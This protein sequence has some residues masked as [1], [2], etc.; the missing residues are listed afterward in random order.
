M[1][2]VLDTTGL[3][4]QKRNK[5]FYICSKGKNTI[6]SPLRI[7]SILI[8]KDVYLSTSALR[9]AIKHKIPVIFMNP[10]GGIEGRVW[11]SGFGTDSEIRKNQVFFSESVDATKWIIELFKLKSESQISLLDWLSNRKPTLSDSI[12]KQADKI[13]KQIKELDKFKD[14]KPKDCRNNI[15]GIEG[16][17]AKYY[18]SGISRCMPDN[19]SFDGRSRQPA[20]DMFNA[21]LNYCYAILYSIVESAAISAGL[22]TQ[23]GIM[24]SNIYNKPTLIYDLIEPFR[25]WVD[26]FIVEQLLT[27]KI[28]IEYF[29]EKNGGVFLNKQGKK[30]LIPEFYKLIETHKYFQGKRMKLKNHINVFAGKLS[31]TLKDYKYDISY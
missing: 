19:F 27:D 3:K 8:T 17:C 13:S 4:I 24:H 6:V 23:F 29:E 28:K 31:L 20:N 10:F 5:C 11:H 7:D 22:D 12:K 2:L 16:I 1:Q 15:L 14:T 9:L 18:W 30:Y 21:T 25:A 26:K